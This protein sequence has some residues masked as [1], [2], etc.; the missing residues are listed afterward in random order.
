MYSF[1]EIKIRSRDICRKHLQ[2]QSEMSLD[3]LEL[4]VD[5]SYLRH[6]YLSTR[7]LQF[8]FITNQAMSKIRFDIRD[9]PV[10]SIKF[11]K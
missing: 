5:Y 6:P 10:F 11:E 9:I 1:N 4:L 7:P 3:A 8:T 2:F